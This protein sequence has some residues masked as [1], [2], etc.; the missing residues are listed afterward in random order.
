MPESGMDECS[1]APS[2][3]GDPTEEKAGRE[4]GREGG[5]EKRVDRCRMQSPFWISEKLLS[6]I[7]N[8]SLTEDQWTVATTPPDTHYRSRSLCIESDIER[9]VFIL[10]CPTLAKVSCWATIWSTPFLSFACL[11]SHTS[12]TNVLTSSALGTSSDALHERKKEVVLGSVP[13]QLGS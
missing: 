6:V 7:V 12:F 10:Q 1:S 8:A 9:P 11:M 13:V 4:G 2:E 5:L 3:S